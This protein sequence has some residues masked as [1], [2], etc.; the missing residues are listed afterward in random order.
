MFWFGEEYLVQLVENLK[1]KF[2]REAASVNTDWRLVFRKSLRGKCRI[3]R[4]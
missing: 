4:R 1:Q 3:R 2:R